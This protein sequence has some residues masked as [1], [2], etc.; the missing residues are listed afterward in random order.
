MRDAGLALVACTGRPAGWGA[1]IARQ[2]P[3]ALAV[4]ENG[5]IAFARRGARVHTFDRLARDERRRRRAQLDDIVEALSSRFDDIPLADDNPERRSDVTFDVRESVTTCDERVA[6]LR[7][8][9]RELGARTYE[10][11]IHVHVTLDSDDKASGTLRAL[12]WALHEDHTGALSHYAFIGDSAN[13]EACFSAF[14]ATF[15]VAN[16]RRW[17]GE[18]TLPPRFVSARA[19]G[20][21]FVEFADRLLAAR[22]EA[23]A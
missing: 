12:A 19:Q 9:A 14:R 20:E 17:L 23:A 13:D 6:E 3:I 10:S 11:S 16:V 4:T 8:V 1:V 7:R 21:G 2:W 22:A 15:A 18:L 5:A